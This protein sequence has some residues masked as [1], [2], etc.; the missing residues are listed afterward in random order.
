MGL[1]GAAEAGWFDSGTGGFDSGAEGFNS[2]NEWFDSSDG[3]FD[4]SHGWFDSKGEGC[5]KVI[6]DYPGAGGKGSRGKG[7]SGKNISNQTPNRESKRGRKVIKSLYPAAKRALSS[8]NYPL[9]L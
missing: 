2:G 4:S 3:W 1:G 7:L 6:W 5:P 9:L 8:I